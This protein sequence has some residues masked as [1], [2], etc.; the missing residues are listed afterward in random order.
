MEWK[1][2]SELKVGLLTLLALASVVFMSVKITSN[3]PGFGSY[4]TYKT[5]LDDASGI[6]EKSNIK[7]AGINAG[8]IKK[9]ELAGNKALITFEMK[10]DIKITK[11]SRL[12]LKSVGFLGDKFL[13]VDIGAA[14]T[15]RL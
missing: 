7:V 11:N 8:K 5:I 1:P 3:Q 2:L 14:D 13:D 4:V 12:Q 9:I 10:E 6:M 15:T